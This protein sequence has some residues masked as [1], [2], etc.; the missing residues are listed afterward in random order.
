MLHYGGIST[1]LIPMAELASIAA[2]AIIGIAL[3]GR[4]E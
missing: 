2:A 1:W 4:D 3:W